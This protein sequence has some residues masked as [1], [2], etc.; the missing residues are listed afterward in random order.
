[1]KNTLHDGNR[2]VESKIFIPHIKEESAE[3]LV[4]GIRLLAHH[5]LFRKCSP[6]PVWTIPAASA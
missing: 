3:L 6:W 1:M 5:Q 2:V 4:S